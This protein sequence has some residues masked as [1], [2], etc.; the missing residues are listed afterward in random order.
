M[1]PS[2]MTSL[3][4]FNLTIVNT[5]VCVM[6]FGRFN[7]IYHE[8]GSYCFQCLNSLIDWL[9]SADEVRAL[10]EKIKNDTFI[11]NE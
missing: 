2:F 1:Y 8:V 11:E 3:V 5:G 10:S 7:G 4:F 9:S 6:L